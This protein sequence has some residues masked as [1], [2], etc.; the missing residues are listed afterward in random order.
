MGANRCVTNLRHIIA[1]YKDTPDYPIGG[2]EK[3][4]VAIVCTGK[5]YLPWYSS[6]GTCVMVEVLYS[7]DCGGTLVSPTNMVTSN[8]DKFQGFAIEANCDSGTGR[9]NI[10]M[11][12][13]TVPTH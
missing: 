11:A 3:D 7:A 10:E 6:E 1:G 2:V 4:A 12:C 9:L 5:G 8:F 13:H